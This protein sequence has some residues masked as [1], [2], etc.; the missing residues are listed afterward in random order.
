MSGKTI[1]FV[2]I[3]S[4]SM[5]LVGLYIGFCIEPYVAALLR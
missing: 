3:G 2:F 1:V 5:A 4:I